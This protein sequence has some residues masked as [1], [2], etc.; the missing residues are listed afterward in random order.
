MIP[1]IELIGLLA[2]LTNLVS[3]VPQLAANL[4]NPELAR[5][6]SAARNACQCAG[7]ALWLVYGLSIGSFAMT[8][9][10]SLGCMMAGLLLWQVL[11]AARFHHRPS[12]FQAA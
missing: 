12:S 10:S 8:L 9:F 2:G 7:N 1:A 6:Q 3:S 4:R 5:G 11:S